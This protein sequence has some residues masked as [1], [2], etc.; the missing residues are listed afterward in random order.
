MQADG[1]TVTHRNYRVIIGIWHVLRQRRPTFPA[2]MAL[3]SKMAILVMREVSTMANS[4]RGRILLVDA[5]A[6]DLRSHAR[7]LGDAGFEVT[8]AR[9]G[10]EA[11]SLLEKERFDAVLCDI[12]MPGTDGLGLVRLIRKLDRD[13]P[14]IVMSDTSNADARSAAEQGALE[15]LPK[16]IAPGALQRTI[17]R[18]VRLSRRRRSLAAYRNLRGAEV[19]VASFTATDAKNE[20]GRVLKKATREGIVVI[21]RHNEP[22]AVVLSFDE[23]K[24]LAGARERKL[25]TLTSEFDALLAKMQRPIARSGMKAAFD[26]TPAR[27]GEA[28]VAASRKRD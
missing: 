21:T 4:S 28:A 15:Y 13:V 9:G 3:Q 24:N 2:R 6:G 19:E 5:D 17:E 22:E 23:F 27:M 20:F 7:V 11:S 8:A 26:A 1:A 10:T 18:A 12:S 16:P 14:V 25:E